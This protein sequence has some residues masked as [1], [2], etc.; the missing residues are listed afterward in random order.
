MIIVTIDN[1]YSDIQGLTVGQYKGLREVLSYP[2]SKE[3]SFFGKA[4]IYGDRRYLLDKRGGFPTGLIGYV[5]DY[6]KL[7]NLTFSKLDK[8]VQPLG[9][10]GMF[11]LKLNGLT[12]YPEQTAASIAAA[13]EHRGI[14]TLPTG[15]GKTLVTALIAVRLNVKTLIVV[16]SVELVKQTLQALQEWFGAASVGRAEEKKNL[17]VEN[18][19]SNSLWDEKHDYH[20]VIIDEYHHGAAKTYRELNKKIWKS[21]YYKF[22]TTATPYRNKDEERM[23]LE[24]ILSKIIYQLDF[25]TAINNSYITPVEAYYCDLPRIEVEGYTWA[26]V[27]NQ[28]VVGRSDRNQIIAS[29]L[30]NLRDAGQSTLCMVKEV[31]HG[32]NIQSFL[33]GVDFIKG[34]N[35]NNRELILSFCLR[36]RIALIGTEGV[37]GEGIDSKPCEWVIIAGLGKSKPRFMQQV[38]RGVRKYPGKSSTKVIIFRDPSHKFT[39][40]HFNAQCKILRDEFGVVPIKLTL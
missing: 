23:L 3:A 20:C 6:L 19:D 29:I 12:P 17:T 26:Q 8:R 22:G 25:K 1:S 30:S 11:N 24:S 4:S 2:V 38:G 15:C 35:D 5:F 21:I 9:I 28:L 27:Y 36:E 7:S 33:Q 39:L 32:I 16:P 37:L 18:I 14:I 40:R 34:E 13:T 31:Q 10:S